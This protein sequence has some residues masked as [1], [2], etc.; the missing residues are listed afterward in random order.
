M[1]KS[2]KQRNLFPSRETDDDVIGLLCASLPELPP[3][4]RYYDDF[5]DKLRSIRTPG[6]QSIFELSINGNRVNVDFSRLDERCAF[7][8]KHV[9]LCILGQDLSI[10]TAALYV[11]Y[12]HHL[13]VNDVAAILRAGPTGIGSVWASL[14]ARSM[15][16]HAYLCVKCLLHMLCTHRLFGW[17]DDYR[18]YLR[19]TLPLPARDAYAGVRSGDVFLGADEE[20]TIV[21]YLDEMVAALAPSSVTPP[22]RDDI[23]DAGMLLCAYQFGMRPIQIAM[24]SLG[25]VRIWQDV[26]EG[27]PTVHLTFHMAKQRSDSKRKPLTR[28]VKREWAPIFVEIDMRRKA[29]GIAS[30]ARFFAVQSN[31]EAGARIAALVRKLIGSDDLGTA[32]DLRHTAAQRLVDAGANHEELAEFLGHSHI[33]TGLVYYETSATHAERVNRALGASDIYRRVAKIAHDRFISPEDLT[34]LKGAQQIAGVPHGIPI[35]GIGGC[36]SGQPACPYNP[37]TSCYGCRKFMPLHDKAMHES[38]LASMREVVMFFEQSSRCDTRSPTY[39][40][41]QRTIAEIQTV[42]DELEGEER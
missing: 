18:V 26:P 8:F 11:S 15:S 38:V 35:A 9:F 7:V 41:L 16:D 36:T 40:Q 31:Y 30:V 37:V 23:C 6:E 29:E 10:A 19:T 21:R 3:A 22:S 42:I 4:I 5:D 13:A 32:T 24:L 20:A 34:L 17:S 12:A 25:N 28:R 33:Q 39:L 27:P 2:P 14:R 1:S